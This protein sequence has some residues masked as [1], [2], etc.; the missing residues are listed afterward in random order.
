MKTT[1]YAVVDFCEDY[2][3]VLRL[4]IRPGHPK[5]GVLG[6]ADKEPRAIFASRSNA[7]SA[8][9]RT[10]HYRLAFG[11]KDMPEKKYCRIIPVATVGEAT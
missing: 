8:I 3:Q 6:W 2:E 5:E 4:C 7:Q 10:E 9:N 1:G 11:L